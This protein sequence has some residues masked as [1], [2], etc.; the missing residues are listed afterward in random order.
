MENFYINRFGK[1]II[2]Y[3]FFE[4]YTTK[5]WGR[6]PSEIDAS[7]GSQRV[8]GISI[9]KVFIDYFKRIFHLE[10][11]NKETSLIES[12]YYPKYGPG[13]L[14]MKHWLKKLKL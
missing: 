9:S 8:K 12:F 1:K 5:V 14:Y 6:P 10:N 13:E 3:L 11:K 2:F 7:W 4:G